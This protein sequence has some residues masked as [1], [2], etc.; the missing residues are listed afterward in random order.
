MEE[1]AEQF[2]PHGGVVREDLDDLLG[3]GL[4]AGRLA[5]RLV[6]DPP[7]GGGMGVGDGEDPLERVDLLAGDVAVGLRHLGGEHDQRDRERG[8]LGL[9]IARADAPDPAAGG[10]AVHEVTRGHAQNRADGAAQ[11]EACGAPDDL[12]PD[13]QPKPVP[14]A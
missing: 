6:P 8:L 11:R 10:H 7:D 4:E 9:L 14:V 2:L 1:R 3:I 13:A 12:A 5:P